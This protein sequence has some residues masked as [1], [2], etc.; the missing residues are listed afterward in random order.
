MTHDPSTEAE[1]LLPWYATGKLNAAERQQVEEALSRDAALRRKLALIEE[2]INATRLANEAVTIPR[3]LTVQGLMQQAGLDREA[4]PAGVLH[5][6]RD[7]LQAAWTGPARFVTAAAL[8]LVLGQSVIVGALL[9]ERQD[10]RFHVASGQGQ[11]DGVLVFVRFSETATMKEISDVLATKG[12]FIVDGP[13]ADGIYSLR[14]GDKSLSSDARKRIVDA[15]A[16]T[17]S[18]VSFAVLAN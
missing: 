18:I 10:T 9:S 13:R 17:Q 11:R 1:L 16:A 4:A 12:Y 7:A 14:I 5:M 8:A 3:S 15:L 2:E 6:L